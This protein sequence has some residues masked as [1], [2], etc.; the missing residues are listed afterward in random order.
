MSFSCLESRDEPGMICPRD[1]GLDKETSEEGLSFVNVV[2]VP[3]LGVVGSRP[4]FLLLKCEISI[5]SLA[6]V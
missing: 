6:I 2:T 3:K 1:I 5:K 4:E